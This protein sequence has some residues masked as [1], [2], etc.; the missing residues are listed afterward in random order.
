[1]YK[2]IFMIWLVDD[3]AEDLDIFQDALQKNG[4]SGETRFV[5]SGKLLMELL[6]QVPREL[7]PSVV[8]LDLNMYVKT[9]FEVLKDMKA[10]IAL[11]GIPVIILSGSANT[12][13]E[14]TCFALGCDRYWKK[15]SSM[16][17][18]DRMAKYLITLF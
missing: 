4:Y 17:D 13:D 16:H 11:R 8:V 15:P 9:G 10:D 3:D 6:A 7:L 12:Y 18:Y 2:R 1:M 5:D 14:T